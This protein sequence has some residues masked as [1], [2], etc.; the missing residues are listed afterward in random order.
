MKKDNLKCTTPAEIARLERQFQ[1]WYFDR[2]QKN[3][4]FMTRY[5]N[6]QLIRYARCLFLL[7]L[8][9]IRCVP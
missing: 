5:K 9:L 1:K 7:L 3:R 2:N 4:Q 6:R 8:M